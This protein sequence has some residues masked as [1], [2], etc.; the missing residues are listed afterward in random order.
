MR[1]QLLT[2][3]F[4]FCLLAADSAWAQNNAST[5]DLQMDLIRSRAVGGGY[6]ID[7]VNQRVMA[8]NRLGPVGLRSGTPLVTA[9]SGGGARTV[10]AR[11]VQPMQPTM[12]PTRSGGAS[13]ISTG[14][15]S[16]P[17]SNISREPTISPYML[18]FNNDGLRDTSFNYQTLVQPM[19]QQQQINQQVNRQQ[20]QI[21]QQISAMAA[22]NAFSVQGSEQLPPT[23]HAAVF[24]NTLNFFP[25]RAR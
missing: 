7:D 8:R 2:C 9:S 13:R 6:S 5:T 3:C 21:N 1:Y 18:L 12:A 14:P 16:K 24:N 4:V 20:Q 23:G 10:G 22:R 11:P 17:F 19:L 25:Q 15:V